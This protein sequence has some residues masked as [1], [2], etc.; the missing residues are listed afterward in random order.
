[1][2]KVNPFDA[3][4]QVA[5]YLVGTLGSVTSS[6]LILDPD[7][8]LENNTDFCSHLDGMIFCCEVCDWWCDNGEMSDFFDDMR[9]EGCE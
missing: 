9:C 6:L 8:E 1:M 7:P 5:N 2:T 3:A 4:E